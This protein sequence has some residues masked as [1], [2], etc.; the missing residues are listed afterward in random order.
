M[1]QKLYC[2]P[3]GTARQVKR[4]YMGDENGIARRFFEA[5]G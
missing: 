5:D 2:S 3:Q 1:I 4:A